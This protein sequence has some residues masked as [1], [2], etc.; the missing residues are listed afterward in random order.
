MASN[1]TKKRP[2]SIIPGDESRRRRLHTTGRRARA[3]RAHDLVG[4]Q[5]SNFILVFLEA[6]DGAR[7]VAVGGYQTVAVADER[8]GA[9]HGSARAAAFAVFAAS[10][11]FGRGALVAAGAAPFASDAQR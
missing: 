1:S 3:G 9:L 6:D 4:V 8:E 11:V 5:Y 10:V 7:G 2:T